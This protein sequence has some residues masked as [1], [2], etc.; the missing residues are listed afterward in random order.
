MLDRQC[1]SKF[2]EIV[3]AAGVS[4]QGVTALAR[5]RRVLLTPAPASAPPHRRHSALRR[6]P[7]VPG[8]SA[9]LG[10]RA[11]RAPPRRLIQAEVCSVNAVILVKSTRRHGRQRLTARRGVRTGPFSVQPGSPRCLI[12]PS[13]NAPRASL[14]LAPPSAELGRPAARPVPSIRERA[15]RVRWR[16]RIRAVRPGV[17]I[18]ATDGSRRTQPLTECF[19]ATCGAGLDDA[20][21]PARG[22]I[23]G[24]RDRCSRRVSNWVVDHEAPALRVGRSS[25]RWGFIAALAT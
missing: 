16:R 1:L 19:I 3:V 12:R 8:R 11:G 10:S 15:R 4:Q 14:V 6:A 25:I 7:C 9:A 20:Q 22:A 18:A 17:A 24:Q 23:G 2:V 5:L 13:G 21:Q